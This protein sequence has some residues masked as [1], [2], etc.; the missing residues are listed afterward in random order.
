MND[1]RRR[2]DSGLYLLA[3]PIGSARDITLRGLDILR[4]ADAIIAEDTRIARRLLTMHGIQLGSRRI[5]SYN[6]V[7]GARRRPE[8]MQLLRQGKSVCYVPDAGTPLIAD[9]GYRLVD[10]ALEEGFNVIAAPGPTAVM[11]ALTVSG[12]PTDRFMFVGF[13]PSSESKRRRQLADL[14]DI[15]AT[16]VFFESPGRLSAC[17]EDMA[18]VL[19]DSRRAAVCRE[20]TKK[21][22]QVERGSLGD[23]S[24]GRFGGTVKG[25]IAVV[26]EGRSEEEVSVDAIESAL[27]E[28]LDSMTV[29]DAVASVSD[30]LGVPRSRVYKLALALAERRQHD[31][32]RSRC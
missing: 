18:S 25:E 9:P 16:M 17:L 28:L 26:V 12:L 23:L 22:E 6:D 31:H 21:F 10:C 2:L 11:A 3:V 13:L 27:K 30:S 7:N 8:V 19:G 1:E 32:N 20:L 24:D 5:A 14:A 29:R 15:G 4:S